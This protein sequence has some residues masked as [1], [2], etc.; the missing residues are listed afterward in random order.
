MTFKLKAENLGK[1]YYSRKYIFSGFNFELAPSEIVAL[2]GKNGSGKT[3][4]LKT[5]AGLLHPTSGKVLFLVDGKPI[6]D[7]MLHSYFGFVAPYLQLYEEFTP[8]ELIRLYSM[9]RTKKVSTSRANQ[10]LELFGL[11]EFRN[12]PIRNFSSGMKQRMKFVLCFASESDVIFL[13]EPFSNLDSEGIE[14]VKACI[15]EMVSEKRTSIV[16]ATND[17][18]EMQLCRRWVDLKSLNGQFN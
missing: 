16:I 13:D 1:A 18:R 3:T 7:D 17:E 15:A 11:A 12:E 14:L 9:M 8:D 6:K 5:L 4:L 10:L 2:I